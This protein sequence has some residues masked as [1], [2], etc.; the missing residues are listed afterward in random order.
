MPTRVQAERVPMTI[1]DAYGYT[2]AAFGK[3]PARIPEMECFGEDVVVYEA[4]INGEQAHQQYN[5]SAARDRRQLRP[6][7]NSHWSNLQEKLTSDL[8]LNAVN[9]GW[10]VTS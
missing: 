8:R 5:V 1:I 4:S 6:E 9:Q 3:S 10:R 2:I 7:R